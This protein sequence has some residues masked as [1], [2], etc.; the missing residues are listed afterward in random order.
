MMSETL[1]LNIIA[2]VMLINLAITL[3]AM[4]KR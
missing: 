3:I 2:V 1:C 4:A